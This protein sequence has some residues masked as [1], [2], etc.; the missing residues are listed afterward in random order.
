M[1]LLTPIRCSN[2][3]SWILALEKNRLIGRCSTRG[4]SDSQPEMIHNWDLIDFPSGVI[5]LRLHLQV[6]GCICRERI[7]LNMQVQPTFTPTPTLTS[8]QHHHHFLPQKHHADA[9]QTSLRR[10]R[11]AYETLSRSRELKIKNDVPDPSI[12]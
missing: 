12:A 2:S 5:T 11:D 7:H 8:T 3:G 4:K 6:L 9:S 1:P 10:L